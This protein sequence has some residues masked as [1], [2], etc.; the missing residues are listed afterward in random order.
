[1]VYH[2]WL[3]VYSGIKIVFSSYYPKIHSYELC[4]DFSNVSRNYLKI[5]DLDRANE[6]ENI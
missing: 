3:A 4:Y 2:A 5:I 6:I 1:M